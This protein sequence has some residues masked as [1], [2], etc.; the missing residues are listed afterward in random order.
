MVFHWLDYRTHIDPTDEPVP[1]ASPIADSFTTSPSSFIPY[2][3][4]NL[5]PS[6][7]LEHASSNS[8][9]N[10]NFVFGGGYSTLDDI[11]QATTYP[12]SHG[13]SQAAHDSRVG[14]WWNTDWSHGREQYVQQA[15]IVYPTSEFPMISHSPPRLACPS[16]RSISR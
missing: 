14:E 10:A 3:N 6:M 12:I 4:P 15:G 16:P 7:T 5:L 2:D 8:S 13:P 1:L 9:L 11:P